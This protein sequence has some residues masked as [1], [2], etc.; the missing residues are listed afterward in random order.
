MYPDN[1]AE[2]LKVYAGQK[3]RP[4]NGTEGQIFTD[5]YCS[6]CINDEGNDCDIITRS[7]MFEKS[8]K[9]YPHEWQY[10]QD[11]QPICTAFKE[12]KE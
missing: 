12:K 2:K 9:D 11:G 3:W 5:T 7:M 8:H 10:G 6:Q 1:L 4:A